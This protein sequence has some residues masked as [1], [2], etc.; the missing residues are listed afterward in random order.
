[1]NMIVHSRCVFLICSCV[2]FFYGCAFRDDPAPSSRYGKTLA[3]LQEVTLPAELEPVPR[4]NIDDIE[5]NYRAALDVAEDPNVRHRILIRLADLEM[6]RSEQTQID[7]TEDQD[8]FGEAVNMYEELIDLNASRQLDEG[9]PS[10]ERLLYKLSKAYALDGKLDESNQVLEKLVEEFPESNYAAEADFRQAELAFSD[11]DYEKAEILYSRVVAA[12]QDTS[13]Y[14]N[15]VYMQGWSQFKRNHYRES[16][17]S[18]TEVLDLSLIEGKNFDELSSGQRNISQDAL[19]I[20][21][22][23]FS[24]LDGSDTIAEVYSTLGT[25]HYE[26]LLYQNLGDLYLEQERFR[27][28]ADTYRKYVSQNPNSDYSPAFSVKAIDVYQRGDFPSFILPAK[29]EYVRNYGANSTYWQQRDEETRK[30]LLPNLKIYLTELSSFYHAEGQALKKAMATYVKKATSGK[31]QKLEKPQPAVPNFLRAADFYGEYIFTFPS[32]EK[33]PELFFLQG[34]AYFEANY[35]ADAI[36]SYET[37]AYELVDAKYG[38]DAGYSAI[39]SMTT[40]IERAA[41]AEN[42]TEQDTRDEWQAHKINSSITFADYYPADQRAVAVLTIAAQELFERKDLERASDTALRLTQWQPQQE[43]DLLKTAWLILSHSQFEMGKFVDAEISYRQLLSMLDT[44]DTDREQVIERIAASI[45]K[46][47]E[48]MVAAE[49]KNQAIEKLLSIQLVAPNSDIAISGQYD[50]ANYLL[51]LSQW[52]RAEEVLLDFKESYPEHRLISTLPAKFALLYQESEQWGKAAETLSGMYATETDP[53]VK[54]DTLYLAAELFEKANN[55]DGA[56][57]HYRIYANTYETPFGLATEARFHLVELYKE[58]NDVGKRDFWLKKLISS[59]AQAGANATD[60]SR[61]LAAY[62]AIKFANDDFE[63]FSQIK[64]TQP[65]KKSLAKKKSSLSQALESYKKV[66]NYGVAE[67]ATESN[68][69]IGMIYAQLSE[70]LMTSERPKGLDELALEEYDI[71]LEDQAYP[72]EEKAIVI[73]TGNAER[74][75]T[76]IYDEWV[77]KSFAALAELLPARYGKKET[78]PEVSDALN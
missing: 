63:S 52:Q 20:L 72:F 41:D 38:P 68:H 37:V 15:A 65:L 8:F 76:G 55:I 17:S 29:E 49:D 6:A 11:G 35:L 16:I 39:L 3:D 59:H 32:D 7:A 75:W 5:T 45:Y 13:F 31:A 50:A 71:L 61:Y 46:Q 9:T 53:D 69:R 22:I 14:T 30:A 23:V 19:R 67:F 25:R 2:M 74:A 28:S 40:L 1:M 26:H 77:K 21:S 42:L 58:T 43:H 70:D 47:A 44:K 78:W 60:R 36:T 27:D 48:S 24:Y 56:I 66:T 18:F 33:V 10:N 62:A 51:E 34:E 4:V 54:R 57:E 64:L 12:G 73:H